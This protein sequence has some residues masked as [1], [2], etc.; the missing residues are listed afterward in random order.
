MNIIL[1]NYMYIHKIIFCL[2]LF[3]YFIYNKFNCCARILT[4]FEIVVGFN[5]LSSL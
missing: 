5:D 1:I 4:V 3:L 2:K